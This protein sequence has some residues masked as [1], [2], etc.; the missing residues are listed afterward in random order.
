MGEGKS[1][2]SREMRGGREVGNGT[3]DHANKLIILLRFLFVV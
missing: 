1:S 2:G 3:S